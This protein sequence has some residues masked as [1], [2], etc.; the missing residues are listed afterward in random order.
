MRDRELWGEVISLRQE[1]LEWD[2]AQLKQAKLLYRQME[3]QRDTLG[4]LLALL[5]LPDGPERDALSL[6]VEHSILDAE[7]QDEARKLVAVHES[8]LERRGWLLAQLQARLEG[9][10]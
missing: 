6:R 8:Q 7:L 4:I 10:E 2:E 3:A 5:R 1:G 9:L